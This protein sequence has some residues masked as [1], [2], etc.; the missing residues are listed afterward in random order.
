MLQVWFSGR[1]RKDK[2]AMDK[3]QARAASAAPAGGT[4]GSSPAPPSPQSQQPARKLLAG[5]GTSP[6]PQ[7][8]AARLTSQEGSPAPGDQGFREASEAAPA[9]QPAAALDTAMSAEELPEEPTIPVS[10]TGQQSP[11]SAAGC[12]CQLVIQC[13]DHDLYSDWKFLL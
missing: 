5:P 2:L 3:L 8:K 11:L 1:R 9:S 4:P 12:P 13:L 6:A 7:A 10:V